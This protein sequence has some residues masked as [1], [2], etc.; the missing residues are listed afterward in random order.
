MTARNFITQ[1]GSQFLPEG[2]GAVERTVESKLQDVVSI[3]DF[4][5]PGVTPNAD[6]L[7]NALATG[8]SV[9]IP[10]GT[11]VNIGTSSPSIPDGAVI[12]LNGRI[13][14]APDGGRLECLGSVTITGTGQLWANKSGVSLQAT[15]GSVF[16]HGITIGGGLPGFA[17]IRFSP[18]EPG[19]SSIRIQGC[20]FD[21]C[22]YAILRS[23]APSAAAPSKNVVITGNVIKNSRGDGIE[24]N[25]GDYDENL[26][27]TSNVIENTVSTISNA[28]FGIGVASGGA[29]DLDD[30]NTPTRNNKIIIS[31]NTINTCFQG[32]HIETRTSSVIISSNIIRNA[33]AGNGGSG[34]ADSGGIVVYSGINVNISNNFIA[35]SDGGIDIRAGVYQ[36]QYVGNSVSCTV[37][38]NQV[39]NCGQSFLNL[40]SSIDNS[41]DLS[42]RTTAFVADNFWDSSAVLIQGTCNF[43]ISGNH[44]Y[45]SLGETGLTLAFADSLGNPPSSLPNRSITWS[46]VNNTVRDALNQVNVTATDFEGEVSWR[47]NIIL[48]QHGN[49]FVINKTTDAA[50]PVTADYYYSGS[51]FPT[52][53]TFNI[54]DRVTS[55]GDNQRYIVTTAG[56]RSVSSDNYAIVNA[57]TGEIRSQNHA[58]TTG[59]FHHFGQKITLSDGSTTKSGIILRIYIASGQYRIKL[60]DAAGDFVDLTGLG[61]GTITS[62]DEVA[63]TTL[64]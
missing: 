10:L 36:S 63:Y 24:W 44:I 54:G 31:N 33:E 3:L 29:S 8:K 20:L 57:A 37:S 5:S 14:S 28:G 56:S 11:T 27:I 30:P 64:T 59:N 45:P 23:G 4:T 18:A 46:V 41:L 47:N 43:K 60:V 55:L 48:H 35:D 25:R 38:N 1:P 7:T 50:K 34:T 62:T 19:F 2:T 39:L 16:I 61:N 51:G 42:Q 40:G 21:S 17:G 9:L 22:N 26:I 53:A 58:W 12:Q 6:S 15:N 32:I 52:G 49:N 13:T